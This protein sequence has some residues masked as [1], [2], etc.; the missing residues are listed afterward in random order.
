VLA[1]IVAAVAV[2]ETPEPK[3][4]PGAVG[5]AEPIDSSGHDVDERVWCAGK[6]QRVGA[7]KL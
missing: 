4:M 1:A 2:R 5:A 6:H 3:R 7:L